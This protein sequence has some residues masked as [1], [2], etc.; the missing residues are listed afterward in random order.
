MN[1]FHEEV[2]WE[3]IL[4]VLNAENSAVKC[5]SRNHLISLTIE[6]GWIFPLKTGKF[7]HE[8]KRPFL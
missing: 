3:N 4:P 1:Y 7:A 6:F 2:Y 5:C 8:I